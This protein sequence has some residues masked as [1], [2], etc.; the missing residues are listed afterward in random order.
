MAAGVVVKHKR[1]TSAFADGE[2]AA[3]EF[4]LDTTNKVW[5]CS[6]DGTTTLLLDAMNQIALVDG[7]T[8]TVTAS[9]GRKHFLSGSTGRTIAMSGA[10]T[11]GQ[12]V[13]IGWKNTGSSP[14]THVL[15][16]GSSNK[17]RFLGSATSLLPTAP[18]STDYIV[19][20][21]NA[22]DSRWDVIGSSG[23]IVAPYIVSVGS[24]FSST[25]V[26]TATLPSTHTT[27]DILVLVLQ[28]SNEANV[29]A[30]AGYQQLGPQNGIGAAATAGSTKL[31][32]FW[33]RD[34]G[35]ESAPTI[36]D[37]GDHTYGMMFAVRGCPTVGDPF[38]LGGNN[39][40]FTTSQ[41]GSGPSSITTIDGTLVVDIFAGSADIATAEGSSLANADLTSVTT[42]FDDG[43]TD[44]TG[45]FIYVA[46]GVKSSAGAVRATTVT[47]AN[48]S[49]DVCTRIHFLPSYVTKNQN[50]TRGAEIQIFIGSPTDLDDL[51]VKPTGAR[52]VFAQICDGG[53]SGSGG[54]TTG[55]AAAGG[56]GGGG[57]YDEAWYSAD[58]LASTITVHAGKGG[59]QANF[60]AAGNPGVV[61]EFD[62]GGRGPL[63]STYRIA[64]TAATA[65]ITADGGNGGCGSG[66]GTASPPVST[67]R[68]AL[69]AQNAACAFGAIGASGGSGTTAPVGG[70]E[71]DWG[72]GGGE[73]GADTDAAI[74][75]ANNGNSMRGGGGGAGGRTNGNISGSGAG[76]GAGGV[77]SSQGA[78]G[79]D[80]THLPYGGSG[81]C[82]GGS[83]TA[84]GGVGGFP[85]GGGGGGGGV[86]GGTG[87]RGGHGC[88]VVTT[89]F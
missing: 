65:A 52:K 72:G 14:I 55:T 31:S 82:G 35:A 58:E 37:T 18:S 45:G 85:G 7:A 48:T 89:Y 24:E 9:K 62:K 27:D 22:T 81:G 41:S 68:R 44:G 26:P 54:H 56:G 57:G 88:V 15:D 11:D 21:Y 10:G 43:T 34:A 5:F 13:V 64:G 63:T 79:N 40:K 6:V 69:T 4:G 73:S 46:S 71:G 76:G 28:Q 87:G 17:F 12:V 25:G 8:V 20:Q 42:Q 59:A 75:S 29:T 80:S 67:T 77:I 83:G 38:T 74:T 84:A 53:G 86:A 19:S 66:R 61:S 47:W 36:P 50:A 1:K 2:L 51:W 23:S 30:P 60:D 78:S 32:I 39:W 49:V 3:G 33:K 16:T 70:S